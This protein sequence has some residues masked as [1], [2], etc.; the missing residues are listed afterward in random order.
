MQRR[1]IVRNAKPRQQKLLERRVI[2]S[3]RRLPKNRTRLYVSLQR[4][5]G[6][7]PLHEIG[8]IN[9]PNGCRIFAKEEYLNPSGSH[10][11]RVY[12]HLLKALEAEEKI[13]PGRTPLIETSS[14]NAGISFAYLA[15][16]LGF[17][18]EVIMPA[19]LPNARIEGAKTH[20]AKVRLTSGR[21]YIGGAAEE[22]RHALTVENKQRAAQGLPKYWSPN[23]SQDFR[24][25]QALEPIAS[26]V[27]RQLGNT[28]IDYVILGV[29][30]GATILGPGRRLKELFPRIKVIAWEPF[31]S[32]KMYSM[33]N[34]KKY[35]RTFGVKPGSKLSH[36]VY[37]TGVPNVQF[38]LLEEAERTV[39]DEVK[40]V[41]EKK[42][43]DSHS[44]QVRGK[45]RAGNFRQ[46]VRELTNWEQALKHLHSVERKPVG[47][48][49]AGSLAIALEMASRMKNKNFLII[50]YDQISR[51]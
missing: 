46:N 45:K 9:V 26:E 35:E 19:S 14:G 20:G 27:K 15:K 4:K 1:V 17:Q 39:V 47:R 37:G 8:Q 32:A 43:R 29:G 18:S 11:D 23:H 40:L 25:A 44:R 31:S 30:N 22:L 10:Y 48:S 34:A 21:K 33:R 2:Q 38:P 42:E 49:S 50:F 28:K 24:T 3:G 5:I 13:T 12:L 51:Y 7:T 41:A 6:N 36:T 16:A